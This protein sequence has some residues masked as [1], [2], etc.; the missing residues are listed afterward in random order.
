MNSKALMNAEK[1]VE[2]MVKGKKRE[3]TKKGG[4]EIE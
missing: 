3:T 2:F 4:G 1:I